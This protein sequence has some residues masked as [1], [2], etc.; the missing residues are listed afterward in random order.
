MSVIL[1]KRGPHLVKFMSRIGKIP[2]LI[3]KL[4]DFLSFFMFYDFPKS[5]DHFHFLGFPVSVGT[6]LLIRKK[7]I[8]N[9]C[10]T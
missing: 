4:H 5:E 9:T 10:I 6:L 3:T 7:E 8:D 1:A 2:C